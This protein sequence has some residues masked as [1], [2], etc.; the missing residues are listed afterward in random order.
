[1]NNGVTMKISL[2][3]IPNI[4]LVAVEGLHRLAGFL[5]I[6]DGKVGDARLLVT[7]AIINGFEHAGLKD[8]RVDVE[9]SM[10]RHR[11][12]ILVKDTGVGFDPDAVAEPDIFRKLGSPVKRGWGLK[13]MKSLSD[14]LIIETG[15]DG[16]RI[17]II[18]HF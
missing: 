6:E 7:E 13:L 1:M 11:L 10:T 16:T 4:E 14:D 2:P 8:P 15:A 12:I 9:F 18:K 5:G 3:N 17:T